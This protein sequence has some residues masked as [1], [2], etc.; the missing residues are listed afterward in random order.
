M[1]TSDSACP[2]AWQLPVLDD[3]RG[4]SCLFDRQM[5]S[6]GEDSISSQLIMQANLSIATDAEAR[7]W[8]STKGCPRLIDSTNSDGS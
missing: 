2:L 3:S 6:D 5:P 7:G 8:V 4:E 1:L